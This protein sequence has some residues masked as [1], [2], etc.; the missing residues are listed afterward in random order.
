MKYYYIDES[1]DADFYGKRGKRLWE[2]ENWN[3]FLLLGMLETE[4]RKLLREDILAF[5]RVLRDDKY[6]KGIASFGK[7]EHF[8]HAKDDHPEIRAE[9]FKFLRG[10]NDFKCY[11]SMV[12]K[13][14]KVF[15]EQFK[16]NPKQ[17]YFHVVEHLLKL[18]DYTEEDKHCFYLSR[19][20]KHTHA[21]FDKVIKNAVDYKMA[22]TNLNYKADV[23]KSSEFPELSVID[24]MLWAVQRGRLKGE[25]RFLDALS[26]KVDGIV[27]A[28][29]S[30][31]N[32]GND[33]MSVEYFIKWV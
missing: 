5:H 12:G 3:N 28:D 24:Y 6:F 21:D 27:Y 20:T 33:K 25:F 18:K 15:D 13:D 7:P 30:L 31:I 22:G 2:L 9:F 4:N 29:G 16:N 23:V 1:G 17:F 32:F 10:R 8:F 19:R 26:D 14:A 11:F